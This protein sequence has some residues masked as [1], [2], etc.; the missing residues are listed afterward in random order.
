MATLP[1]NPKGATERYV[2]L[3]KNTQCLIH[4]APEHGHSLKK[5]KLCRARAAAAAVWDEEGTSIKKDLLMHNV[6]C[7]RMHH[8]QNK[9]NVSLSVEH[10]VFLFSG[11]T[12]KSMQIQTS[13]LMGRRPW[14]MGQGPGP[15]S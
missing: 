8:H 13:M 11:Y 4:A 9:L 10:N 14:P 15:G 1:K 3:G 5:R 12:K 2:V 7:T 6:F